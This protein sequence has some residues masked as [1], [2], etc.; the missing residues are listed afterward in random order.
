MRTTQRLKGNK[1]QQ[2][3]SC[4]YRSAGLIGLWASAASMPAL[5]QSVQNPGF[6][7]GD[8]SGWTTN[9]G[10]WSSGWPVPESQYQDPAHLISVMQAGTVDS[11]TGA[12]TVFEGNYA[13]RLNDS[14]GGNDISALSQVVTNYGGNKL[15][16][17]WNAVV[18]PSHGADDSP[19][20]LIK[21][22][23]QTTN[24]IV[25]NIAYSAYSAATSPIFRQA[26]AFVTTDWKVEDIDVTAG[27]D[28][29]LVFVAVDCIYGAH[30]GYVYV[31]GFGNAIPVPNANITFNPATD[32]TRGATFLIPIG[33]T[34]DIDLA[35]AFYLTS[36]VDAGAVLPN[37]IG[38]TLRIDTAGPV[39]TAFTVQS[40]GGTV[41]TDGN[42]T[43][44]TGGLTGPGGLTK[45]G[46]GT[47]TLANVNML[48]GSMIVSN[49][50]L[51]IAGT[52]SALDV[53][54]RDGGTLSGAG[55]VVAPVVVN[56]GGTLAPG[57]AIG[58]LTVADNVTLQTGSALAIDIDG[59]AYDAAGGA[60][61]YDRLALTAG[62]VFTAGGTIAPTLGDGGAPA[63]GS[64]VTALGDRFTVV[65]ADRVDGAAFAS[66]AQPATGMAAN[67]RFDVLYG[68]ASID[69]VVTPGAFATLGF[70]AGWRRN[71]I[72]AGAGLDAVRPAAGSRTGPLQSLFDGLYGYEAVGYGAA[73]QQLSG[74]VHAQAM[75][76]A[77]NAAHD[78]SNLALNMSAVTLGREACAD[79]SDRNQTAASKCMDPSRR[80][81]LWTQLFYQ[82]SRFDADPTATGF[83]NKQ[84][85]F[86]TGM[87]LINGDDTR[88]GVGGRYSDNEADN[89][90]G[91]S[92]DAQSYTLF[93]Y[94][95]HDI[96]A[97]TLAGTIGWGRTQLDVDRTQA[98]VTGGSVSNSS[99]K[100]ETVNAA[101]EAR[102]TIAL[103]RSTLRP[104]LGIVYDHVSADAVQERNPLNTQLGLVLPKS[105]WGVT[106]TK[107]GADAAIRLGGALS[108]TAGATWNHVID[109]DPT[110][111]RRVTLGPASWTTS[112]VGVGNNSYE[113]GG[114]IGLA[115]GSRAKLRLDYTGV[116]DGRNYK[117]DRALAGLSY[118][119]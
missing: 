45:V 36:A 44:F 43:V 93:S 9:G 20:F 74:E 83:T 58:T 114:G 29:K 31:D 107:L 119:F 98:L 113:F 12:P 111:R 75:E 91:G 84:H 106:R 52:L 80:P 68:P 118:A 72:A 4:L 95:S 30:G 117:S 82:K 57:D 37:F 27:H 70:T 60:G 2:R 88:F 109:G 3:I 87:H 11:I 16:Y 77:A 59:K 8:A 51:N 7:T 23:D 76:T 14:I 92:F 32:V 73:L 25:T 46:A 86:A 110:A 53:E 112:S 54:V 22:V 115:L 19:S 34:P 50:R 17:A 90:V 55:G 97:L 65:T 78:T 33:G 18:E 103:G 105:A 5:A 108:V 89:A 61:T 39:A 67:T 47:L 49:G 102:F 62:G 35:Q 116:R 24:T 71:A 40:A 99:Y 96:G 48:G 66:V 21:V 13:L 69:L 1:S 100:M 28:Y 41:D 15:Y 38:G 64:F 63:N 10:Y 94:A 26:G 85:G 6:E 56:A 101:L 42:A 104:V 79:G 81:A